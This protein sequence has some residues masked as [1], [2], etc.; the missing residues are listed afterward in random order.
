M[1]REIQVE[2]LPL[3]V[4]ERIELDVSAMEIGDTLRLSDLPPARA[5]PTSTIRRRCSRP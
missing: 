2:A 3:E 5:S 1:T 4:P